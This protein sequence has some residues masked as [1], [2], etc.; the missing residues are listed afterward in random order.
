MLVNSGGKTSGCFARAFDRDCPTSMSCRHWPI[1]SAKR[2]FSV[3][4]SRMLSERSKDSPELIIVAN[5]REKTASSL[6]FT[7]FLPNPGSV[8]SFCIPALAWVIETGA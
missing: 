5:C 3:C 6:S 2:L 1:T 7:F 4:S 8:S